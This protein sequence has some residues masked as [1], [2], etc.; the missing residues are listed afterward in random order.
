MGGLQEVKIIEI[1]GLG[2]RADR[3]H[4]TRRPLSGAPGHRYKATNAG[5]TGLIARE[6][7]P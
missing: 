5:A 2:A 4:V 1:A 3:R 6:A 7:Q